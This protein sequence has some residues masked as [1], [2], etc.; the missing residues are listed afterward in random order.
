L[1]FFVSGLH[2]HSLQRKH[3]RN[4]LLIVKASLNCSILIL[5]WGKVHGPQLYLKMKQKYLLF[6]KLLRLVI[7]YSV[8]SSAMYVDFE[9]LEECLRLND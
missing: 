7:A 6:P 5:T 1:L 4:C 3:L 2:P 9:R 8:L